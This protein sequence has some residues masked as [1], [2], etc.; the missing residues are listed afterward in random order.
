MSDFLTIVP[1]DWTEFP[2]VAALV[3]E[4][5]APAEAIVYSISQQGWADIDTLLISASML[6]EGMVTSNARL[7]Y[8]DTGYRFW[9]QFV[10]AA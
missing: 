6:P 10:P 9:A 3:N 5:A 2:T 4:S 1:P 8:T 7:I